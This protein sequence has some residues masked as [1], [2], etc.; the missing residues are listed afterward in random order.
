MGQP[1][2][3]HSTNTMRQLLPSL[4]HLHNTHLLRLTSTLHLLNLFTRSLLSLCTRSLPSPLTLQEMSTRLPLWLPWLL[5]RTNIALLKIFD[6][7]GALFILIS[8]EFV[9]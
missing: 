1:Q 2:L 9:F 6:S 4:Q 5:P 3:L 7:S 8:I